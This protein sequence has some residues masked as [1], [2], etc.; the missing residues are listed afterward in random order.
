MADVEML[1]RVV[2]PLHSL[3]TV[4]GDNTLFAPYDVNKGNYDFEYAGLK[5]S[6]NPAIA[7]CNYGA[8]YRCMGDSNAM[9]VPVAPFQGPWTP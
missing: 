6:S 8:G 9:V 5:S 1:F 2:A 4:P 7:P 3:W